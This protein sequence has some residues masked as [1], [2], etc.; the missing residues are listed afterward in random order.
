MHFLLDYGFFILF[1]IFFVVSLLRARFR[2]KAQTRT[3][4]M[5]AR[6]RNWGFHERWPEMVGPFTKGLFGRGGSRKAKLGYEGIFDGLQ[7]AGFQYQ[8]STGS[9][10]DRRTHRYHVNMVSIPGARFPAL[11]IEPENWSHRV[12]SED[13]DFEDAEFNRRW[14]VTCDSARFA[15]DVIHP[16][17]MQWLSQTQL[18]VFSALWFEHDA[19]LM[20]TAGTIP[21]EAVDARLRFLTQWAG[22]IPTFVLKDVGCMERPGITA[23]GPGVT[24]AEQQHRIEQLSSEG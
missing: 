15:H 21:P 8:Y 5:W 17:V 2:F 6:A 14:H 11:S 19:I 9:G 7:A 13:I 1:T 12:F 24:L 18:P 10:K 4:R 3:W 23:E 22:T 20:A 16:R